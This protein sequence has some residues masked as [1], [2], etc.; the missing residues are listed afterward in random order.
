[1]DHLAA[2]AAFAAVAETRSFTAAARRLH[3][4]K[5]LVSRQVAALEAELGA[6]LLQRTTR[7]LTLTEAGRSYYE[8]VARILADIAEANLSVSQLQATPRGR[9]RVN[10]PMSFG[11]RHIAPAIP[12]FLERYPEA[13]LAMAVNDRFVDP[14][15]EGFDLAVRDGRPVDSSLVARRLAP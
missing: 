7:S 10:A 11:L 8:S 5:S 1:M 6:R 2:M 4:S 15:D 3:A 13:A 9:L 12:D 14:V